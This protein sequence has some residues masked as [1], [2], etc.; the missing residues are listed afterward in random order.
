MYPFFYSIVQL[1]FVSSY[2]WLV[3]VFK[4]H[5]FRP[6]LPNP[7]C[8]CALGCKLPSLKV[9]DRQTHLSHCSWFYC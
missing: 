6:L 4:L 2:C 7:G 1:I 5:T 9:T 3:F 8:M